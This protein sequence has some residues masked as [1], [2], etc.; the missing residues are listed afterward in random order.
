MGM[1]SSREKPGNTG[2]NGGGGANGGNGGIRPEWKRRQLRNSIMGAIKIFAGVIVLGVIVGVAVVYKDQWMKFLFGPKEQKI[3]VAPPPAP[4]VPP[5]PAKVAPPPPPPVQPPP[6]P[7]VVKTVPPPA[8]PP[9]IPSGEEPLAAKLI[10]QGRTALDNFEFD[11][12]KSLFHEAS[13][14][15]AGPKREE[16]ATWEKKSEAFAVATKHIEVAEFAV[17]DN[18]YL[19]ETKDGQEFRGLL[20]SDD[21]EK[22]LVQ[23]VP[24][25]NPASTGKSKFPI[26]SSDISNRVK[27]SKQQRH[28][29][30]FDLV[31]KLEG[32]VAVQRSTDYYD[33]VFLSK[34]LGLGHECIEFLNRAYVGGEK[35]PAD[36]YLGDSFRKEVIRRCIDRASLMLAAGRAKSIVDGDLNRLLRDLKGYSVAEDEVEA[37]R[38]QVMA[39]I[40]DNFKSTIV[41]KTTK[42][43]A[44]A[45]TKNKAGSPPPPQQSARDLAEPE[46]GEIEVS[47]NGVQGHG[48][49][50]PIVDQANAKY[51]EGMKFYRGFKQGSNGD[52]NKNLRA[53]LECLNSAIDMYDEA[54]KK[55]PGNQSIVNRQTEASMVAYG[56]RKY[57]TL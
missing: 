52:N 16:A 11:K 1:K 13:L 51:E 42:V 14:K 12:A 26:D 40:G 36:P 38:R 45:E 15:K 41:L 33:L 27:L 8:A 57:Q 18:A 39:K 43:P 25:N 19:I 22:V 46:Q 50:A 9:P 3:A 6:P 32:T 49:A 21:G 56:C 37:F 55:D 35:H 5:P 48:S 44:V 30:F 28:D 24:P 4:V 17:A 23:C 10:E 2:N 47:S 7:P 53:A 54:L 29:E 31:S 20:L 34:R